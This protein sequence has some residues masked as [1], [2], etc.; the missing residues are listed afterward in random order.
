MSKKVHYRKIKA[1]PDYPGHI[2]GWQCRALEHHVV[3]WQNTG[4]VVPVGYVLHHKNGNKVDN[5][6]ENLELLPQGAHISKH[7]LKSPPI[8][9]FCAWCGN[10][11]IKPGRYIRSKIKTQGRFF[12]CSSHAAKYGHMSARIARIPRHGTVSEYS[13]HGCRCSI[14]REAQRLRH[15]KWREKGAVV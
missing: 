5:R 12:C 15:K 6:F 2:Y 7:H 3:W 14:C 9:L 10:P 11:I 4:K 1:P 13:H 8:K